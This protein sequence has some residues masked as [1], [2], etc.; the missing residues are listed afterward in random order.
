MCLITKYSALMPSWSG[1]YK[2]KS[3]NGD[4]YYV[5]NFKITYWHEIGT[6]SAM[7]TSFMYFKTN[8]QDDFALVHVQK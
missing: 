6:K 2:E 5:F 8:Y 4:V 3:V 7:P 1:I